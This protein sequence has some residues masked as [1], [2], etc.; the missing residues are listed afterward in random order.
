[1]DN[2]EIEILSRLDELEQRMDNLEDTVVSFSGLMEDIVGQL[3]KI[4]ET[5]AAPP[6][7]MPPPM[8]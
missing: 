4:T 6:R 5:L 3:S 2:N 8:F 7:F 1:M